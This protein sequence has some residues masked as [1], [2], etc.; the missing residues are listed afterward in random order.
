MRYTRSKT[1]RMQ[2]AHLRPPCMLG[3]RKSRTQADSLHILLMEKLL[4]TPPLEFSLNRN[5]YDE[6]RGSFKGLEVSLSS[7]VKC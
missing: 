6:I 3:R 7:L 1:S 5:E 4:G 2:V